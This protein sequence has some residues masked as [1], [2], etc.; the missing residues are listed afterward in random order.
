[1]A[2]NRIVAVVAL[3]VILILVNGMIFGKERQLARGRV[4]YLE[5]APVDPRSLMQGDY[6]ALRFRL[7]REVGAALRQPE[8]EDV[9]RTE[10]A[11][12]AGYL[13]LRLDEHRVGRFAGLYTE[14]A[15]G[16]NELLVRYRLAADGLQVATDAFFF[17]EGHGKY[18]EDAKFGQ[19][20]VSEA[21][22][23]LLTEMVDKDLKRLLPE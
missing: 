21:G 15:L 11:T 7:T 9:H 16:E 12:R 4:V 10:A 8:A 23:L 5:L 3:M 13:V 2:R 19:F 22:D 18:Y 1:M 6:M 14:Q 20:R 17:Q